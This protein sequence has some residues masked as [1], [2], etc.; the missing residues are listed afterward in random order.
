LSGGTTTISADQARAVTRM[1]VCRLVGLFGVGHGAVIAETDFQNMI[2]RYHSEERQSSHCRRVLVS[3]SQSATATPTSPLERAQLVCASE[4]G[5][6][7]S[8]K[9]MIIGLPPLIAD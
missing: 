4:K 8:P 7:L 1:M 6:S 9:V 5:P 3:L 2:A